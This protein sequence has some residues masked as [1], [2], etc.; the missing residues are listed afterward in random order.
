MPCRSLG[1]FT[2]AGPVAIHCIRVDHIPASEEH[3]R[4]HSEHLID[5]RL[6]SEEPQTLSFFENLYILV[7]LPVLQHHG[8]HT[9]KQQHRRC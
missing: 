3:H 8:R 2:V 5:K 9:P 4:A 6:S 1:L 7:E